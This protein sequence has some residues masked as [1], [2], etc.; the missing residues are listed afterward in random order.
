MSPD[1][2]RLATGG[3][4]TKDAVK[5][6]DLVT[7][8]E[9]LSLPGEGQYFIYLTFSPDGNTLVAITFDGI[10][11]VWRAPSWEEIAVAEKGAVTP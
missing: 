5:L 3:S 7:Q 9:L 10:A 8:R 2:R 1:G 11:H 4:D 6:W